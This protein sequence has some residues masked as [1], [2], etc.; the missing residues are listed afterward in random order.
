[1]K[2]SFTTKAAAALALMMVS[3][4]SMAAIANTRHNLGAGNTTWNASSG[5]TEICV[6]C[7][8]P[9]GADSAA[10]APLWNRHLRTADMYKTYGSLGSASLDTKQAPIGSVSLACLSCHDGTQAVNVVINSPGSGTTG[11]VNDGTN[12]TRNNPSGTMKEFNNMSE[13]HYGTDGIVAGPGTEMI[14]LATDLRNDHPISI[15]YA[16]D[17][18][19]AMNKT[20]GLDADF[21]PANKT[22]INGKAFWFVDSA[23]AY[24]PDDKTF[25]GA[26]VKAGTPGSYEKSDF[27]LYT[28]STTFMDAGGLATDAFGSAGGRAL[29]TEQPFV[30]CA[31]CHDPH[32]EAK[33]F[34]RMGTNTGSRVCL[35]CHTK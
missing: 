16:G 26:I 4:A 9:H 29:G 35:T 25:A 18:S 14:Y 27:K 5:T 13:T 23:G 7:H 17:I 34:L 10:G 32:V 12:D 19:G 11:D 30:E 31:T 2:T 8:T 6:F 1:M 28:R 15:Q 20:L 33:T 24:N 21:E 3:S 22:T